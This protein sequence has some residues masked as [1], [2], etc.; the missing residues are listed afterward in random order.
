MR[1]DLPGAAGGPPAR[2]GGVHRGISSIPRDSAPISTGCWMPLA[3]CPIKGQRY[4]LLSRGVNLTVE[5]KQALKLLFGAN[6]RL[7]RAYLASTK[8]S[9]FSASTLGVVASR[10]KP[11]WVSRQNALSPD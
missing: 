7:N 11:C 6:K 4:H 8:L 2:H 1:G 5:G 9:G 3:T 10:K